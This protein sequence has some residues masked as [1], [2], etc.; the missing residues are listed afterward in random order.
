M[1]LGFAW[2]FGGLIV[3][4]YGCLRLWFVT[5]GLG[6]VRVVLVLC[7]LFGLVWLL[8]ALWLFLVVAVWLWYFSCGSVG[9]GLV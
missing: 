8:L 7:W 3:E 4:G 6:F 5:F 2:G 1:P 9:V